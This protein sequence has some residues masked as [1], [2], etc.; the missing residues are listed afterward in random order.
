MT[1]SSSN[2][3]AFGVAFFK[4]DGRGHFCAER[5]K[6]E[7]GFLAHQGTRKLRFATPEELSALTGCA[8]GA[9]PPFGNLFGLPVLVD[10]ELCRNERV[11]FNAGSNSVSITM[12]REDLVRI[13]GA[14]VCRF[15]RP[16]T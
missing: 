5:V 4:I 9:V 13:S 16:G 10:A 3:E 15:A 14:T 8:P 2:R 6:K 7:R 12:R 11:A 1:P